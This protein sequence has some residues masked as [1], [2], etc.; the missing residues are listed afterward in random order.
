MNRFARVSPELRALGLTME[1][2]EWAGKA[3]QDPRRVEDVQR[4]CA[5]EHKRAQDIL[6][7]EAR[8]LVHA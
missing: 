6:I 7:E 3:L 1:T 8:P 5:A 4:V 2:L